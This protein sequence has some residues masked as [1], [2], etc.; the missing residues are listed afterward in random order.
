[1][2]GKLLHCHR[3]RFEITGN[4]N[5]DLLHNRKHLQPFG[6]FFCRNWRTFQ[7]KVSQN[8]YVLKFFPDFVM[9]TNFDIKKTLNSFDVV[10]LKIVK[11]IFPNVELNL[12]WICFKGFN[13]LALTQLSL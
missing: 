9:E 1:M 8:I 12:V 11:C 6:T 7:S 10:S 3:Q 5:W 4:A 2:N 13:Q